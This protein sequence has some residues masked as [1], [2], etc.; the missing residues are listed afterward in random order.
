M[1]AAALFVLG[2]AVMFMHLPA[3][4]TRTSSGDGR[5]ALL[6][7][8]IWSYKHTVLG[9]VGIFF[10]VGLQSL[11]P[12]TPSSFSNRRE[13]R[14]RDSG[15]AGL[16]LH[17]RD[18]GGPLCRHGR[19]EGGEGRE[20]AGSLGLCGVVAAGGGH[21]YNRHGRGVVP[22]TLRAGK[23]DHVSNDLC[24]GHCGVGTDDE[25]GVGRDHDRQRG[26]SRDSAAVRLPGGE[27]G[28]YQLAFVL[29]II[30]YLFVAYY[31]IS[32]YKPSRTVQA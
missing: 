30:G 3:I 22:D 15:V 1:I 9:M 17:V 2:F 31:G 26:R 18:Y 25:Q 4:S 32:G 5:R 23:L 13:R 20:T 28:G 8:S 16:V 11:W 24:A 7:R 19:D 27:D 21:V 29:P 12:P 14:K 6:G 10:Y